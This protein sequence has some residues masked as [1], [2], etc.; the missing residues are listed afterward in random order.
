[1]VSD[2]KVQASDCRREDL[3]AAHVSKTDVGPP[4]VL[5]LPSLT[6]SALSYRRTW[7]TREVKGIGG[8]SRS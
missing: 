8:R 2:E 5:T 6:T 3:A 7:A 1:M 4:P